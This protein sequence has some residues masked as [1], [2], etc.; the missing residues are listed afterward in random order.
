MGLQHP[1][2]SPQTL[3]PN[4]QTNPK[5]PSIDLCHQP[6]LPCLSTPCLRLCS[7]CLP[8]KAPKLGDTMLT[9][10][11]LFMLSLNVRLKPNLKLRPMPNTTTGTKDTTDTTP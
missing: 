10:L 11:V 7:S 6:L 9:L 4:F 3:C 1:C 2:S 5:N 8:K